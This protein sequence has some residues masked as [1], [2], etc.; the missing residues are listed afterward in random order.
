V[1]DPVLAMFKLLDVDT[2]AETE[3]AG[4][5]ISVMVAARRS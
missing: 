5:T 1:L 2:S 3:G 4:G